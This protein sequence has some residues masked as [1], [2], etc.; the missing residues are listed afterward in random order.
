MKRLVIPLSIVFGLLI[1][2]IFMMVY[3]AAVWNAGVRG[4]SI[5]WDVLFPS[6]FPFFVIS[7]LLLGLGI[8]HFT[9]TLLHPLMRPVFRIPGT[10]GFVAAISYAS[11]YPIGAKLTAKLWEKKQITRDEGERLVAFTTTSDPIF[12]IGAVSVG[13]FQLPAVAVMLAIA[14]YGAGL[15]VGLL[16]RFHGK[17]DST[18]ESDQPVD[19]PNRLRGALEAMHKARIEDGR[20]MGELLRQAIQSSLQLITVVGGL[21]VFFCV[22]LEVF[23]QAGLMTGMYHTVELMLK[24]LGLPPEISQSLVGGLFE[25]TL[26]ARY[27]GTLAEIPLM[28][29]V[30]AA[31][32]VLSWG[33]LSV[34]AQVVS[35][36]NPTPLRYA[37]FLIARL[38][39]A[40]LSGMIVFLC[41][42]L[43]M[44]DQNTSIMLWPNKFDSLSFPSA[45]FQAVPYQIALTLVIISFLFMLTLIRILIQHLSSRFR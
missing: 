28:Y 30:A 43:V 21:V 34:H 36:L 14:H 13:F 18:A 41:W 3:P 12:L 44:F 23:T 1:I 45:I 39:H 25:V 7:E 33:G 26:G 2:C 24:T 10:G 20:T 8:V 6:L 5:W 32:C 31:A 15:I 4:L 40:L 9:G 19:K 35:I 29:K 17:K 11:G 16:M 27:A 38:V 22:I 42:D 37:P